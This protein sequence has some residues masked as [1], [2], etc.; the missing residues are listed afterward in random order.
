M[1]KENLLSNIRGGESFAKTLDLALGV[2]RTASHT[3]LN[4]VAFELNFG[5]IPNTELNMLIIDEIKKL[6]GNHSFLAKPKTASVHI[7]WRRR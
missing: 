4:K 6:G 7:Q 1:L 5:R 2:M 3:R